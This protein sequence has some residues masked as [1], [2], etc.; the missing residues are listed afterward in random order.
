MT[1]KRIYI[2]GLLD[3]VIEDNLVD[4]PTEHVEPH[5]HTPHN[6]GMNISGP[7]PNSLEIQNIQVKFC[8]LC[9]L[10]YFVEL[11]NTFPTSTR[12]LKG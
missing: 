4:H 12:I 5:V 2:G 6:I 7:A 9:G 11:P 8:T 1:K 10:M 3:K